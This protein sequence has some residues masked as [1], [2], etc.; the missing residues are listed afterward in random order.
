[1]NTIGKFLLRLYFK[2]LCR[3][4]KWAMRVIGADK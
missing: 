4:Y 2:T 1:M 3:A